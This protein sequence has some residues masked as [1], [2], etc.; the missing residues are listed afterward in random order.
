MNKAMWVGG[1]VL[2]VAFGYVA[3]SLVIGQQVNNEY[4]RYVALIAENYQ[5]VASVSSTLEP[6][7]LGS[8]NTLTLAFS[9]LPAEILQWAGGNTL[10]F[11]IKYRHQFLS[12]VSEMRIAP[13]ALLEKIKAYQVDPSVAP[14]F[15]KSRYR[16]DIFQ[17]RIE[18]TGD[19]FSDAIEF[20]SAGLDLKIGSSVG[21]FSVVANKADVQW[22]AEPS[23]A[24]IV[25]AE[26][27]VGELRFNQTLSTLNGDILTAEVVDRLVTS[28]S[29]DSIYIDD[30]KASTQLDLNAFAVSI[31]KDS[32]DQRA[33]FNVDYAADSLII[34]SPAER[35][36]VDNSVLEI[37]LDVDSQALQNFVAAIAGQ[38]LLNHRHFYDPKQLIPLLDGITAKGVNVAIDRLAISANKETAQGSVALKMAA[39]S[40]AQIP[41]DRLQALKKLTLS[42]R[43]SLPK[44]FLKTMPNFSPE[45]FSFLLAMGFV[46]EQETAY[47]LNLVVKDG[48]VK[49]NDNAIPIF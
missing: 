40:L 48:V 28:F 10:S 8:H 44:K 15:I 27:K 29:I 22:L 36:V 39:F 21:A 41:F 47:Y 38:R 26:F 32:K 19:I 35:F 13:G 46:E 20:K 23:L 16:Y 7:L 34:N 42:A 11:D 12:S 37:S 31:E 24:R 2:L 49:L 6:S 17:R 4:R 30:I 1:L 9:D 25:E 33:F 18:V 43:L 3:G 5:G 45:Q 14:L